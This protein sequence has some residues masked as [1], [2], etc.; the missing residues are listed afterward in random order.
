M[1]VPAISPGSAGTI[2][3]A[4][5]KYRE[6]SLARVC[7]V[8]SCGVPDASAAHFRSTCGSLPVLAKQTSGARRKLRKG[9]RELTREGGREGGREGNGSEGEERDRES[10]RERER[11]GE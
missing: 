8:I 6:A 9:E 5:R 10:E 11:E 3:T 2:F 1:R 7:T 4:A